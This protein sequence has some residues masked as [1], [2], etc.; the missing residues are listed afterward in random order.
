MKTALIVFAATLLIAPT[1]FAKN[2]SIRERRLETKTKFTIEKT[3]A[4]SNVIDAT[5]IDKTKPQK[6]LRA[7]NVFD[8]TQRADKFEKEPVLSQFP[9]PKKRRNSH[10]REWP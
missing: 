7:R 5:P 10:I 8:K 9:T 4:N 6:A 2:K 3:I 1:L